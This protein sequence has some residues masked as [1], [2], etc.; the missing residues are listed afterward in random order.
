MM[1]PE[2]DA[3]KEE[4]FN[5]LDAIGVTI[6]VWPD[7]Y[8]GWGGAIRWSGDTDDVQN[9]TLEFIFEADS[10][11][12][13][14]GSEIKIRHIV[15]PDPICDYCEG[16]IYL[17][18]TDHDDLDGQVLAHTP[19]DLIAVDADNRRAY[20]DGQTWVLCSDSFGGEAIRYLRSDHAWWK[21]HEA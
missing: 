4:L 15:N 7:D 13:R 19:P 2:H 6:D 17:P 21:S 12:K 16:I 8:E 14:T 5:I 20:Y 3:T 9:V 18:L 11:G 1:K 10:Y